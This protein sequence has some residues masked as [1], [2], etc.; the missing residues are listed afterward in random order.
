MGTGYVWLGV[1]AFPGAAQCLS[2]TAAGARV[3]CTTDYITRLDIVIVHCI[4]I[5]MMLRTSFRCSTRITCLLGKWGSF[6]NIR[7]G[8]SSA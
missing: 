1:V 6:S 4:D 7:Q 2:F 3:A 5:L 8:H